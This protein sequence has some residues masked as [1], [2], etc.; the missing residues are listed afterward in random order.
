MSRSLRPYQKEAREKL[1]AALASGKKNAVLSL[2]PSGGKT[3]TAANWVMEHFLGNGERVLWLV[4]RDELSKQAAKD[5]RDIV[6]GIN[7][8]TW[9]GE[10]KDS[11]GQVVILSNQ[12]YQSWLNMIEKHPEEGGFGCV[13]IDESHHAT[14]GST[15]D[16]IIQTIK[17][18]FMLGLSG[19]PDPVEGKEGL[20]DYVAYTYSFTKAYTEGYCARPVYRRCKTKQSHLFQ[21]RAGEFTA[22]SLKALNNAPRNEYVAKTFWDHRTQD[23]CKCKGSVC[24]KSWWPGMFY[25]VDVDHAWELRKALIEEGKRRGVTARFEVIT[26]TTDMDLRMRAVEDYRAGK[27]DG[28]VNCGVFTEGTDIAQIRSIQMCRPTASERLWTQ[29][30]LRGGRSFPEFVVTGDEDP[31]KGLHPDNHYYF[32]D[33]VDSVQLAENLSRQM[34]MRFLQPKQVKAEVAAT[35]DFDLKKKAIADA[36]MQ[37]EVDRIVQGLFGPQTETVQVEEKWK[38]RMVEYEES[39]LEMEEFVL[40]GV[41]SVLIYSV[42]EIKE[43][44]LL[45]TE[46]EDT[47]LLLGREYIDRRVSKNTPRD[48]VKN[49]IAK[50]HKL[51]G[52]AAMPFSQWKSLMEA[53]ISYRVWKQATN[54]KTG[55]RTWIYISGMSAPP[56]D[57]VA[58][59]L[60]ELEAEYE[61]ANKKFNPTVLWAQILTEAEKRWPSIMWSKAEALC[62]DITWSDKVLGFTCNLRSTVRQIYWIEAAAEELLR[63]IT[64]YKDAVVLARALPDSGRNCPK[65]G[66]KLF[67]R[68]A[69]KGFRF[70]GC[71]GYRDNPRCD[72]TERWLSK[73]EAF[74]EMKFKLSTQA[75]MPDRR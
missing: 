50:T 12:S 51:F 62:T 13:V 40:A 67:L 64:G 32:V 19:T 26:G 58:R 59:T 49:A 25:S 68:M 39:G 61:E 47:A 20:F 41:A 46:A 65:C 1:N 70:L 27:V 37:A 48:E 5:F 28:I 53:Y 57:E 73:R 9:S 4:H 72:F 21:M 3:F 23:G 54:S 18:S 56:A 44:R 55:G 43:K 33:Y 22:T 29:I 42:F 69:A 74:E 63:E 8:T 60:D 31:K 7:V 45:L 14:K 71:D 34:A 17:H 36:Q 10:N 16:R 15:Y 66:K 52:S 35:D 30:A 2:C 38:K 75:T 11:S 24:Q 6:P